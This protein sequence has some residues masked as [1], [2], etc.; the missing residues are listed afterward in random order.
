MSDPT[1]WMSP[2]P[3]GP[4]QVD[5][6]AFTYWMRCMVCHGDRGQG[7]ALFRASYPKADQNCSSSKC[8]GGPRPGAG[9]SFPDAPAIEGTG[10]LA[11]FKT[12]LE[13]YDF[14]STRMPYQAPAALSPDEYWSLVAYLLEQRG[15]LPAGIQV[16]ARNAGGL[17]IH[18]TPAPTSSGQLGI[19]IAAAALA[20]AVLGFVWVKHLRS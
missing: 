12:A 17:A 4:S 15:T 18:T 10:T 9:F 8:H 6:G 3:N 11:R 16:D 5:K 2:P 20:L 14:I 13:L 19:A 1:Q 7:L